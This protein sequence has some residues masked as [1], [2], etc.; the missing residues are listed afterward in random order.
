MF[1]GTATALITPFKDDG[2][3]DE[4]GLR[5]LVDF[6]EENGANVLI[7]CGST[8]ESATLSHEEHI[9]VVEIVRDQAKHAKIIAGAGSNSTAEAVYL[10]KAA[11]DLGCDGILSISP[12]YNKP[13]QEGIYLHFKAISEAIDIPLIIYNVPGRTGSNI[14]ADTT[15]RLAE[16]PN[17]SAIKEA[18]GNVNQIQEILCK[19][20]KGF[21]VLSGDDG[22]TFP[23]MGMGCDGVISVA[24]NC[25][26][27]SMSQMINLCKQEK[28][29]EAREIHFKLMPLFNDLF[30][31]SNPIPIKYVM[32]RLGYGNGRPRLPLTELSAK[33]RPILDMDIARLGLI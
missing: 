18:S 11:A 24:A 21:E 23:L 3:V 5:R 14:T 28:Y 16:L 13:T 31:E 10:S 26:P 15:L 29:L 27:R 19:R 32:K 4:G 6:Q 7:P 12:Y 1:G 25:C 9:R 20:P 30:I 2:S 8:G 17:I 33:N 22:L